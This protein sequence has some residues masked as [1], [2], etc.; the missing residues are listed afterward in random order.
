MS[1]PSIQLQTQ[2]FHGELHLT[3]RKI[4]KFNK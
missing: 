1:Q 4:L 2:E 3:D